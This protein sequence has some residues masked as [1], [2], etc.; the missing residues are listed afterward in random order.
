MFYQILRK[1]F[2]MKFVNFFKKSN[3]SQA[4][5]I[6]PGVSTL[7]RNHDAREGWSM[8]LGAIGGIDTPFTYT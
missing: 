7:W 3:T 1:S 5:G 4:T 6:H 2:T 8:Y